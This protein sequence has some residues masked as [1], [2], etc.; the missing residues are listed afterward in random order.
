[1]YSAQGRLFLVARP[2]LTETLNVLGAALYSHVAIMMGVMYV[3]KRPTIQRCTTRSSASVV[4][5]EVKIQFFDVKRSTYK[6]WAFA[7]RACATLMYYENAKRNP[8]DLHGTHAFDVPAKRK[9]LCLLLAT[10]GPYPTSITQQQ[11][12]T[13]AHHHLI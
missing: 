11:R 13:E 9:E 6:V 3:R 4:Q 10:P 5:A 12:S 7:V 8:R 1:M 2:V